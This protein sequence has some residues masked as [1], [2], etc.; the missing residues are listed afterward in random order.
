MEDE[1]MSHI[2]HLYDMLDQLENVTDGDVMRGTDR[3]RVHQEDVSMAAGKIREI[4]TLP[5]LN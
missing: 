3:G 1:G 5:L 2:L 4:V